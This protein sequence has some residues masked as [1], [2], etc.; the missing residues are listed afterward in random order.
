MVVCSFCHSTDV[1]ITTEK[2][3]RKFKGVINCNCCGCSIKSLAVS[4]EEE[5]IER[6][7]RLNEKWLGD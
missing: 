4:T 3:G 6:V 2:E 5:A 1:E 7:T